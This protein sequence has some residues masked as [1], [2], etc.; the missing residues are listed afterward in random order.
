MEYEL[1]DFLEKRADYSRRY[2]PQDN[3]YLVTGHTPTV[4]IEGWEKVEVYRKHGHIALDCACVA[5]GKLAAFCVE[6]E[7]VFYVDGR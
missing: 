2:Y 6:T 7:E 3:I 4:Y 5:G 1:Y